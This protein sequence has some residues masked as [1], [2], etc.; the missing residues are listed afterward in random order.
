M[1]IK[2]LPVLFGLKKIGKWAVITIGAIALIVIMSQYI[3]N[4]NVERA[5]A[6]IETQA[7]A[8]KKAE[9]E[10]NAKIVAAEAAAKKAKGKTELLLSQMEQLS[11]EL[12][13]AKITSKRK[14]PVNS[15]GNVTRQE[16]DRLEAEY[17]LLWDSYNGLIL[18]NQKI[19]KE[20]EKAISELSLSIQR[21]RDSMAK[22]KKSS[23]IKYDKLE[24]YTATLKKGY[25]RLYRARRRSPI[26][27]GFG[28]YVG[29]S[30]F[31]KGVTVSFGVGIFIDTKIIK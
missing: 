2:G 18:T 31:A 29:K 17:Q 12:T 10:A 14:R 8:V 30:L 6:K 15:A 5:N 27:L 16:Y 20:W 28:F 13:Q 21:E 4:C 3:G 1:T 25:D 9:I 26:R 11:Q 7:T 22:L 24:A 19:K 23:E